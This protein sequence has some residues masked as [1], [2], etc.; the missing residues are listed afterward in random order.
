MAEAYAEVNNN[1]LQYDNPNRALRSKYQAIYTKYGFTEK[2][3]SE[4]SKE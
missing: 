1:Y 4:V 3:L 2:Q